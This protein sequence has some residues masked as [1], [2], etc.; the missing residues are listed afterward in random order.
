MRISQLFYVLSVLLVLS[1]NLTLPAVKD[2][3]HG[4]AE[5]YVALA[6]LIAY[7]LLIMGV[8]REV[9]LDLVQ[10]QYRSYEAFPMAMLLFTLGNV[11]LFLAR[12]FHLSSTNLTFSILYLLA[13]LAAIQYGFR[14]KYAHVRRTG[15]ALALLATTKLFIYDLFFLTSFNKILAYF[16][17][18]FVLLGISYLYQRLIKDEGKQPDG[19]DA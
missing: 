19:K 12:Q 15:L 5:E 11:T 1:I 8:V 18:G 9:A 7:N 10:R 13:G 3:S 6:V 16:C 14:L 17:F 2:I 4:T